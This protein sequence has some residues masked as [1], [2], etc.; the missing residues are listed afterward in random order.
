[1][2]KYLKEIKELQELKDLLSSRDLP[3]IIVVDAEL[4]ENLK[5]WREWEVSVIIDDWCNR[6][7]N[8]DE[9]EVLYFPTHEDEMDYIRA[10]E[11]LEPL[12][13]TPYQPYVTISKSEWLELLN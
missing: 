10:K 3:E 5:K 11:G 6:T 4:L 13:R 2:R 9:T 1:M 12:Y 7:L 8:E